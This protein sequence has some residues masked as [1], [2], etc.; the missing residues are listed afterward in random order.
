MAT[1]WQD[2]EL[3]QQIAEHLIATQDE[4]EDDIRIP[5]PKI[6]Y[7]EKYTK[8]SKVLGKCQKATGPWQYLTDFSY[9]IWVWGDWFQEATA[10]E[11]EALIHHELRHIMAEEDEDSGEI[12]WKIRDHDSESFSSE[13][14]RYKDWRIELSEIKKAFEE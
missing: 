6:K 11:R 4:F 14:S 3:V 10:M 8:K 1:V 9:V 13:V 5:N 2:S 7:L 12:K